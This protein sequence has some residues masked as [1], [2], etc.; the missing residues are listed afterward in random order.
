[1]KDG[2]LDNC[3]DSPE[4]REL[5]AR[6]RPKQ[7]RF[8][9]EYLTDFNG[10]AAAR[11]AGYSARTAR[12][13]ASRLLRI[14]AV[15][16]VI[17]A[18]QQHDEE[19]SRLNALRVRRRMEAAAFATITDF[20]D[21]RGN[22]LPR[23]KW[24]PDADQ[25]VQSIRVRKGRGGQTLTAITLTNRINALSRLFRLLGLKEDKAR[26]PRAARD[27]TMS[28]AELAFV[29]L[30]PKMEMMLTKGW[31]IKSPTGEEFTLEQLEAQLMTALMVRETRH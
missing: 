24:P 6:L 25:G 12:Q 17:A 11:R 3:R 28:D 31:R 14:P 19:A 9:E 22:L 18:C 16:A 10:T 5:L 20:I 15:K 7:Q 1:M 30:L 23:E 21:K 27:V 26:A 29:D 13:Q 4:F 8:V 2:R